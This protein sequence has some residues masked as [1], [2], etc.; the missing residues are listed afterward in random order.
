MKLQTTNTLSEKVSTVSFFG[1]ADCHGIETFQICKKSEM[2]SQDLVFLHMRAQANPQRRAVVFISEDAPAA[3][4]DII[5][6]LLEK[7]EHA[8]ALEVVKSCPLK[9]PE[10]G[11]K[12]LEVIPNSKLDPYYTDGE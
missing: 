2:K 11:R 1:L 8:A 5:N 9:V 7:N 10:E 3:Y 6:Q 4:V 12:H